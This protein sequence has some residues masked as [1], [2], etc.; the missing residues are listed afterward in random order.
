MHRNSYRKKE[1][2]LN[3]HTHTSN[4]Y[5]QGDLRRHCSAK[6][7]KKKT[8]MKKEPSENKKFLE[9]KSIVKMLGRAVSSRMYIRGRGISYKSGF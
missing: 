4:S 2:N 9:T 6:I 8:A 1:E 7:E 5:S 3:T